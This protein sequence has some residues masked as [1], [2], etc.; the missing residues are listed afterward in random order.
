MKFMKSIRK[1]GAVATVAATAGALIMTATTAF[2]A[3]TTTSLAAG[4]STQVSCAG[5]SLAWTQSDATDGV[6]KCAQN[7]TTT[8]APPTS[9]VLL[10]NQN[11]AANS[12]TSTGSASEAFGFTAGSSGTVTSA[13]V[14]LATTDGVH[15]ALY[16]NAS[17]KPGTLLDQGS[18]ATNTAGWVTV[19]LTAGVQVTQGT[20]YWIA[21]GST[22]GTAKVTYRDTGSSGS[23]QDFSGTGFASPY[24]SNGQWTSNPVSAYVS[25]TASGGGTTTTTA[26]PP[27]TTPPTTTPPTTSPPTTAPSGGGGSTNCTS[28]ASGNLGPFDYP[29]ITNSNG[30]NTY[31]S[32]NMW[33]AQSGTTQKVCGDSPGNWTMTASAPSDQGGAVQTYPDVQQLMDDYCGNFTWNS[34]ANPTDSPLFGLHSLTSTYSVVDPPDSQGVWEAAYDIWLDN[35]PNSEIMIWVDTSD[36]RGT[37]GANVIDP[38]VSIDGQTYTYENYGGGLPIM[39]LHGNPQSATVNIKDVLSYL[40]SQGQISA[41]ATIG[42]LDFGWEIC[43]TAG[44]QN[45]AMNG[46]SLTMS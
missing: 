43:Q 10:G 12:D 34:C 42:Q 21:L 13:S 9:G 29:Q 2:G 30:F 4:D 46:Y 37:G 8:T 5:P 6:L 19:P 11:V 18:V 1:H 26:P 24:A 7:P 45:F 36:G 31:V 40:E 38:N 17:G 25:G 41:N 15:L 23:N 39:A 33:G 16:S 35:T 32:N 14:Y 3:S 27:T 20:E 22:G 28:A 44:T